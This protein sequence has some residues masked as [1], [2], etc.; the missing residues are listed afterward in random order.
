MD[1]LGHKKLEKN[2]GIYSSI[3]GIQEVSGSILLFCLKDLA[4]PSR[5]SIPKYPCETPQKILTAPSFIV[6]RTMGYN[7]AFL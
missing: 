6:A 4:Q 1:Y 2:N 3:D 7:E 5:I